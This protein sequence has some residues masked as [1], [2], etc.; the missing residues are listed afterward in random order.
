MTIVPTRSLPQGL[1]EVPFLAGEIFAP[2]GKIVRQGNDH[3][4]NWGYIDDRTICSTTDDNPQPPADATTQLTNGIGLSENQ[5]K[6]QL[7]ST[8]SPDDATVEHLGLV[9][10]HAKP[11]HPFTPK[12]N[13]QRRESHRCPPQHTWGDG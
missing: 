1:P 8:Q 13:G 4:R 9:L 6:R 3:A 2:I 11:T 5:S 10:N 7:W 12:K